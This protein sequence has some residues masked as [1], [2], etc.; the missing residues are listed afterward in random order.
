MLFPAKARV[1]L[2]QIAA[3]FITKALV[4]S[5]SNGIHQLHFYNLGDL[6]EVDHSMVEDLE[7]VEDIMEEDLAK[8]EDTIEVTFK[9][10]KME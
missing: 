3:N 7:E 5:M 8:E 9:A 2:Q 1:H 10:T 6:E 4:T